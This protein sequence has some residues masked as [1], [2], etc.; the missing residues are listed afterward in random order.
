[1]RG[2]SVLALRLAGGWSTWR[3]YPGLSPVARPWTS[4]CPSSAAIGL[5]GYTANVAGIGWDCDEASATMLCIGMIW[6]DVWGMFR[7]WSR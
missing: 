3:V 7:L 5:R 2:Y 4:R 1:M 6:C